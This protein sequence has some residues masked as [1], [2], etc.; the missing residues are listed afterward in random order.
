M[1]NVTLNPSDPPSS[2]G[3]RIARVW[4]L[5]LRGQLVCALSIGALTWI[6]GGGLGLTG[7]PWLG[8]FAG[9]METVPHVGPLV[10]IVP[11]VAIA[12]WKGSTV[13]PVSNWVFAVIIAGAYLA[14][15]QIG[16]LIIQPKV[17]GKEL[18]LPPLVV[19]IAIA[20]GAALGGIVGLYLAI[21]L[22]VTARELVSYAI[23]RQRRGR[24]QRHDAT[25]LAP[26][27][28]KE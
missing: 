14:I 11:A 19:L 5:Y 1:P 7:A 21:P 22:L 16:S 24:K 4:L 3:R 8:M 17:L 25:G 28:E 23:E 18:D 6:V 26:T 13:I 10:A 2:L 27:N 12:L 9:V 20:A 15:Q